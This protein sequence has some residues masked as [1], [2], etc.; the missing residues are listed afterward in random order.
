MNINST[1]NN[2]PNCSYE[3]FTVHTDSLSSDIWTDYSTLN[4][5]SFIPLL[6]RPLE[7]I[8][9][10]SVQTANIPLAG[11]SNVCYLRVNEL[12][13]QFNESTGVQS[14]PTFNTTSNTFNNTSSVQSVPA[15]KDRIRGSLAKFNKADSGR[16]IYNQNDYSTQTQFITPINKINRLTIELLNENG[17][18]SYVDSNVFVSFR[19]TCLKE[20][21]CPVPVATKS[22]KKVNNR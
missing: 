14:N 19:F 6:F 8:V 5:S 18:N 15:K 21:L 4:Q 17:S 2:T 13:S 22:K 16:T 7:N 10:V 1:G 12:D 20:N 9:Q 11:E 3:F